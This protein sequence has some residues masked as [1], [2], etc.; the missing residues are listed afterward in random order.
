PFV[1]LGDQRA[2][3]KA[4][5]DQVWSSSPLKCFKVSDGLE[6]ALDHYDVVLVT[7]GWNPGPRGRKRIALA[8]ASRSPQVAPDRERDGHDFRCPTCSR[9]PGSSTQCKRDERSGSRPQRCSR[10][11]GTALQADDPL[12]PAREQSRF[13]T[14]ASRIAPVAGGC[15]RDRQAR[16]VSAG[17]RTG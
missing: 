1:F 14:G 6:G 13:A 8:D 4:G 2:Y 7:T 12:R 16:V 5:A 9:A 15:V 10:A 17:T 11:F 3:G